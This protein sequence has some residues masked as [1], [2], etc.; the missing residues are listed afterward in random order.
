MKVLTTLES[1]T[2]YVFMHV[3]LLSANLAIIMHVMQG[4]LTPTNLLI[5]VLGS[6][7]IWGIFGVIT[8]QN[9]G[10]NIGKLSHLIVITMF[11]TI[12]FAIL[13]PHSYTL[14]YNDDC[15]ELQKINTNVNRND[16]INYAVENPDATGAEII[17]ALQL[18]LLKPEK[19]IDYN[20]L[21]RPLEP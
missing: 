9:S 19:N 2:K 6:F 17:Q 11:A 10:K 15:M 20:V 5:A 18:E 1:K 16:C 12:L 7:G 13:A 3:V 8:L 21:D 4:D 14:I